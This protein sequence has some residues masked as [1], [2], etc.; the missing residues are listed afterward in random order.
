MTMVP[1]EDERAEMAGMAHTPPPDP[2]KIKS[3]WEKAEQSLRKP[4]RDYALNSAFVIGEQYLSWDGNMGLP[5]LQAKFTSKLEGD[6][7][8]TVNKMRGRL[9]SMQ[10]RLT[11]QELVFEVQASGLDDAAS[12]RQRIQ[13][14]VLE[15]FRQNLAWETVRADEVRGMLLGGASAVAVEVDPDAGDV[16]AYDSL[17][18]RPIRAGQVR[19]TALP[20]TEFTVEPGARSVA[21][22]RWW[23]RR[24]AMTPEAAQERY[25]LDQPPPADALQVTSAT[26]RAIAT[27]RGV[28]QV[29]LSAVYV[30]YRRPTRNHGGCVTHVVGGKVVEHVPYWPFS[31]DNLNLYV[32]RETELDG[33]WVGDTCVNDARPVQVAYNAFRT[34]IM[35]HGAK[36][37]N[38][39]I[40]TPAGALVDDDAFSDEVAEVVE[41]NADAG[42]PHWMTP[43]EVA[44]WMA[45]QP[46]ELVA[47]L[48]EIFA[49]NQVS[50][51]Q[52]P[53]D[54][55]SGLAL[56]ILAEKNDTP[57]GPIAADQATGW[58]AIGRMALMAIREQMEQTGRSGKMTIETEDR[59]PIQVQWSAQDIDEF[60]M[61]RV[62]KDATLPRSHAAVQAQLADLA[63]T[64]P[65]VFNG[66]DR[67]TLSRLLNLPQPRAFAAAY[68][69]NE[70]KARM[71]NTLLG[72]GEPMVPSD[73]EDHAVHLRV[74]LDDING[75]AADS[76]AEDI[77][78]GKLRHIELHEQMLE[79]A[80]AAQ[81]EKIMAAQ[82]GMLPG[83][84]PL[85]DFPSVDQGQSMPG[86][87]MPPAEQGGIPT[88]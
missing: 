73:R 87:Q 59:V 25:D 33:T 46:A 77:K 63:R 18:G 36:A 65:Q 52:A 6:T 39:R 71:E 22:A 11:P 4:R 64:F 1:V 7:R 2:A 81:A 41:F 49:T 23:M 83:A 24:T 62:P 79:Q 37:A 67:P 74:H 47:E 78:A 19:L 38:A 60:P 76:D 27:K 13:E 20:I 51:G 43:P 82:M 45:N 30:W 28:N 68:E 12:T 8:V 72:Q 34:L 3:M 75:P 31:F 57:L 26:D 55:N 21:E 66:L 42:E 86:G 40:L 44:R 53:G 17:T 84:P 85:P 69:P 29:D 14:Q 16:H 15:A 56:S 54:R 70:A 48:D 88:P 32:F 50:R 61:V 9:R 10:A 35:R 58:S 80:R 5:T